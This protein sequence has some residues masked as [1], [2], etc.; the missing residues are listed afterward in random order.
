[1][2]ISIIIPAYNE[3][4][5]ISELIRRV[6]AVPLEK[7]VIVVDD[8]STDGTWE[9][10]D[11]LSGEDIR[12]LRNSRNRGKGYCLRKGF[13]QVTGEIVIIQDA[14]LEYYPDEYPLLISLISEGKADVVYGNRFIGAHRVFYFYHYLGNRLLNFIANFF[15]N[16]NLSDLMTGYKA[17]RS[18]VLKHLELRADG[19]G[20][21]AEI[22]A[23]LFRSHFRVYEVPISY[24]GREYDEGKKISFLDFFRSVYWLIRCRLESGD[25]EEETLSRMRALKN[26]NQWLFRQIKPHLG[27]RVIEIGSG[28]GS[29]SKFLAPHV[30]QVELTDINERYLEYLRKRFGGDPRV[31]V[32]R[33]DVAAEDGRLPELADTVICSNVIE[34]VQDDGTALMNIRRLLLPGGKAVLIVPALKRLYGSMDKRL[35][36]V[37]RYEKRELEQKLRKAGLKVTKIYFLNRPGVGGWLFNGRILKRSSVPVFQSKLFDRLLPVLRRLYPE[38]PNQ[39]GLSLV[40]VA[41]AE[42]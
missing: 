24:D 7:E 15:Y 29:I 9:I 37:R 10:L 41:V 23:Q 21:E 4:S 6:R 27:K 39:T 8:A 22:T 17:F 32:R 14:D 20:V 2:K 35:G 34:H 33:L 26:Y 25:V 5:T 30:E 18:D 40:V 36:H 28:I 31:S 16:T 42:S 3:R 1:M 11:Q 12:L 19:F 38:Q 13:Q